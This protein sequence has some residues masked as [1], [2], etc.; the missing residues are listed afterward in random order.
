[1]R[2]R[3]RAGLW[4][5]PATYQTPEEIRAAALVG[6]KVR[7]EQHR[8]A[9]EAGTWQNP[10]DAPGAREKLSQPRVHGDDPVLHAALEKLRQGLG[11]SGLTPEEAEAHRAYRRRLRTAD[12]ERARCSGRSAYRRRVS[13]PEGQERE[14]WRWQQQYE[15]LLARPA[16]DRMRSARER[17]GLSQ[18]ALAALVGVSASLVS[19]WERHSVM[20]ADEEARRKVEAVLGADIWPDA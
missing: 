4:E 1:M 6:A 5:N 15:R 12:P 17:A 3:V 10:A 7:A 8:A 18:A 20:P 14:R 16:N 19:K 2:G 13:T 11:V 9:L